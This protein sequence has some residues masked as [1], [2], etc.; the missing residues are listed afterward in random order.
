[1]QATLSANNVFW[2]NDRITL[3]IPFFVRIKNFIKNIFGL[4]GIL[5]ILIPIA[6]LLVIPLVYIF[7]IIATKVLYFGMDSLIKK[8]IDSGNENIQ[9]NIE[10]LQ[11]INNQNREILVKLKQRKGAFILNKVYQV[12]LRKNFEFYIE[13]EEEL[14]SKTTKESITIPDVSDEV[15]YNMIKS[16]RKAVV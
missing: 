4:I 10:K 15:L 3:S 5:F 12:T 2:L 14:I 8:I 11:T 16:N 1:M 7:L 6:Y 13:F 9:A